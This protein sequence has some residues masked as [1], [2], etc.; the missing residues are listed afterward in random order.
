MHSD[1]ARPADGRWDELV[2]AA[3]S[4][5]D[6]I[7]DRF[8]ERAKRLPA[9][10]DSP[11]PASDIR[12]TAMDSLRG[13]LRQIADSPSGADPAEE[14]EE[15]AT[16]LGARRARA[17][18]PIESLMSAV[19]LDFSILWDEISEV[20]RP[21]DAPLLVRRAST[22]WHAVDAYAERVHAS[23][24][25]EVQRM[26][27]EA[28]SLRQDLVAA[29]F[30][31]SLETAE[32][33]RRVAEGLGIGE[34]DAYAV[35][36]ARPEDLPELREAMSRIR[37][38]GE[39]EHVHGRGADSV[40]FWR[41]PKVRERRQAIERILLGVRCG[42]VLDVPGLAGVAAAAR[43]ATQ[44]AGVLESDDRALTIDRGWTRLAR[45]ALAEAGVDLR[46]SAERAL[47]E[48]RPGDREVLIETARCYLRTG[49]VATVASELYCHRNTV[50][51]RLRRIEELTGLDV[52][53]PD[54]AA[55]LVVAWG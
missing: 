9:Y 4:H 14:L 48:A 49:S 53:V 26:E 24:S 32:G 7:S 20:A 43:T 23:Y 54:E 8:A 13:L 36:V 35:A 52:T 18:I 1:V 27:Q 34:D 51:N 19:R 28:S 38:Q 33:R 44:L 30:G 46:G 12:R 17:G 39:E 25:A 37:R 2:A 11:V 16:S 22:L 5:L 31:P 47:T 3:A 6:Q 45:A 50:L 40:V 21:E 55:R 10:A 29:V 42:L 41:M 15:I